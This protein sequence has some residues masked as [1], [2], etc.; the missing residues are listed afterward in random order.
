MAYLAQFSI[1][2]IGGSTMKAQEIEA[3]ASLPAATNCRRINFD[4]ASVVPGF[5]N[6]T[7]ILIVSGEKP[8]VTMDVRLVPMIYIQ[9]PE[10]WEIEVVGCL[11]G[12]GLPETAPYTVT[13][14]VTHFIGKKGIE[15]S[16]ATK[17]KKI[18]IS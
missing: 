15:I 16:G 1:N 2:R 9:Q 10:Y 18:E 7:W 5:V 13:L 3:F 17:S 4:N 8:W 12:V 6:D 14:E 11:S